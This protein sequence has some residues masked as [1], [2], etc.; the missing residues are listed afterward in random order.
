MYKKN[1]RIEYNQL[2]LSKINELK[3]I[4]MECD[5]TKNKI[6]NK[7]IKKN[8]MVHNFVQI[9]YSILFIIILINYKIL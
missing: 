1:N 2:K 5:S 7:W 9:F 4:I 6:R 8:C 3:L